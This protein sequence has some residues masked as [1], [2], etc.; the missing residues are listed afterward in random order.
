MLHAECIIPI[1][2]IIIIILIIIIKYSNYF[3]TPQQ[4]KRVLAVSQMSVRLSVRLSNMWIVTKQKN[5]LPR[6][7]YHM[8]E[9]IS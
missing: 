4:C 6:F 9:R 7:L 8:K 5:I 2:V 3:Y 1:I